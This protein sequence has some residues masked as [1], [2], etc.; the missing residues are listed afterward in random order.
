[1][2]KSPSGKAVEILVLS[3]SRFPLQ[4]FIRF[5]QRFPTELLEHASWVARQDAEVSD[6]WIQPIPCALIRNHSQ[7]YF[8]LRR[9]RHTRPDLRTRI[10]LVV[11]GHIDA[12]NHD[13]PSP[14]LFLETLQRELVEELRLSDI[15]VFQPIG[16]VAD[17]TSIEASR[18]VAFV[19][20]VRA[21]RSLTSHAPE[22][23]SR[24]SKLTAQFLAPKE[25]HRLRHMLDPWSAILFEDYIAP[26]GAL[27]IAT[28]NQF[29]FAPGSTD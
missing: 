7:R 13:Q 1:M 4:R 9:I 25:L 8:T 14:A 5:D 17:T 27:R 21:S 16:I 20:E 6:N 12:P 18:H 28:Q 3:R 10:S 15:D 2:P 23:F 26:Q 24:R 22:E 19:Y 29:G 11:G